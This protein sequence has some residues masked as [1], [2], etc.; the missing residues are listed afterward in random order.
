MTMSREI[1]HSLWSGNRRQTVALL[2]SWLALGLGQ[3]ALGLSL[4]HLTTA[5]LD[6][7]VRTAV[8]FAGTTA[9]ALAVLAQ[10]LYQSYLLR[11]EVLDRVGL[12]LTTRLLRGVARRT[13]IDHLEDPALLD[14]IRVG[15]DGWAMVSAVTG[16]I[17]LVAVTLGLVLT[18]PLLG[19]AAS[20]WSLLVI[21][22]CLPL[23]FAAV[24]S[25]RYAV[26]AGESVAKADRTAE[27][28]LHTAFDPAAACEL[29]I[30][31][32]G[33]VLLEE[34]RREHQRAARA[35]IGA[36]L[37]GGAF[38]AGAWLIFV[39]G[40]AAILCL[41]VTQGST[42]PADVIPVI[43]I[44]LQLQGI[45]V[46]MVNGSAEIVRGREVASAHKLVGAALDDPAHR[47][48]AQT[49]PARIV[50][51]IALR[52][53]SFTYPRTRREILH[54][55]TVDIPAGSMVALVG[56]H[57]SGK[58]TLVKLLTRMY[59]PTSG[60]IAVDG[61]PL[62]TMDV[63]DWRSRTAACFQDYVR[64]PTTVRDA[65]AVGDLPAIGDA[66]RISR[67][68]ERG[69]ATAVV[70]A[71]PDGLDTQL[72]D[73]GLGTELSSGQWQ[74]LAL[75]RAFMRDDPLLV[76]LDEPTASFDPL[77]ERAMFDHNTAIA[78]ELGRRHG[79]VTLMISHRFS[80][81]QT[82]DLILVLAD[83][84]L[85]EYGSHDELCRRGGIY[86][87]MYEQQR[88]AYL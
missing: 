21:P 38:M 19:S 34:Y 59:E 27:N 8:V 41:I 50:R 11:I 47:G 85:H 17:Q 16:G 64:L 71:L 75:A 83:G 53:V 26:R 74:R 10:A 49:V 81:V 65:V 30:T 56:A 32:A 28:L 69:G 58:S 84:R 14:R 40:F 2:G 52:N 6:H 23:V 15:V 62:S 63:Q 36:Q 76:V 22:L 68:I 24:R 54:E 66:G 42:R 79:T 9:I 18:I 20:I 45:A 72:G 7:R 77:A 78:H 35:R 73:A 3:P 33:P 43:A 57:G 55:I 29:R 37:R 82:A 44:S 25:F 80:T 46:V 51:G 61:G 39:A 12:G 48:V 60:T 70:D 87:R 13:G 88:E 5:A 31:G 1:W 4:R 86:A 67:A